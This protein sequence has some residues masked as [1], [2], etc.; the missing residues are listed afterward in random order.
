MN[1]YWFTSDPLPRWVQ[2][3]KEKGKLIGPEYNG[4]TAYYIF[5]HN[6]VKSHATYIY[7]EDGL[8]KLDEGLIL[9]FHW[10]DI[11]FAEKKQ[12]PLHLP[13]TIE[14]EIDSIMNEILDSIGK[15]E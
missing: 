15:K 12:K 6:D 8:V 1:Q 7:E 11:E 10:S 13:C 4:I 2:E 14:S 9:P 5:Y 3:L